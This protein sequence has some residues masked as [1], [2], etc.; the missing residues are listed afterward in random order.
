MGRRIRGQR[1]GEGEGDIIEEGME[2]PVG[3]G[4]GEEGRRGWPSVWMS[5]AASLAV[6]G[7]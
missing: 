7:Y 1:G 4:I 5:C 6:F 3:I 2:R